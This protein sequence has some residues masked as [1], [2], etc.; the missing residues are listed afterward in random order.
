[1]VRTCHLHLKV[2]GFYSTTPL[3]QLSSCFKVTLDQEDMFW[4]IGWC[5]PNFSEYLLQ[6][7]SVY[8]ELMTIYIPQEKPKNK[9][10]V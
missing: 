1:M 4:E 5:V 7:F 8:N 2:D 6:T 3:R 10:A 9:F